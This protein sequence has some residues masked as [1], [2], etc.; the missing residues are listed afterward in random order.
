MEFNVRKK[1][2]RSIN[3]VKEKVSDLGKYTKCDFYSSLTLHCGFLRKRVC[4]CLAG[5]STGK[6]ICGL[7]ND[8]ISNQQK[9]HR[10][11]RRLSATG[12]NHPTIF[13]AFLFRSRRFR[14][15]YNQSFPRQVCTTTTRRQRRRRRARRRMRRVVGKRWSQTKGKTR[16]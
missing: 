7:L 12:G 16:R 6:Y 14:L 10:A 15:T 2:P 8:R 5:G 11:T 13:G 1:P 4:R 9:S 3:A